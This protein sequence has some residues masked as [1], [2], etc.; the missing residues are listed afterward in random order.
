MAMRSTA[1]LKAFRQEAQE[2]PPFWFMRQAGRY[3][4]EYKRVRAGCGGFLDLCYTPERAA[5]VTVQPITRFGMSAA[6]IFSDILV[7]PHA[8]GAEVRFLE[9]EGPVLT[10]VKDMAALA[11]LRWDPAFLK[12][13]Y[14]ALRLTRDGLPEQTTLIGFAGAPWT[15]ACY[16]VQGRSDKDFHAVRARALQDPAFFGALIGLLTQAVAEHLK[17]QIR[18][19]AEVVQLFDSWAGALS[20]EEFEAWVITP[21]ADIVASVKAAFP[22]IP[23]IGFPRQA[24]VKYHDYARRTGVD[25]ISI[26]ASVPLSHAKQL[27][28]I[29]VVQGNLDPV[30]LAESKEATLAQAK[31]ILDVMGDKSFVFNL[32]H[33]ILPH[34]PVEHVAALCA[35]LKG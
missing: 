5:E 3:L 27:Q 24:G 2:R 18:A 6:I 34:T 30:L 26:D 29:C 14:E 17:A 22:D 25:G 15:L 9:G 1:L 33:G 35:F 7:V 11:A 4:A 31:R 21:T 19:G 12:P 10:P 13:V 32:G 23:V 8:L 28:D 16:M 20:A